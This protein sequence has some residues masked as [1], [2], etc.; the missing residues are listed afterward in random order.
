[1]LPEESPTAYELW[2]DKRVTQTK[3]PSLESITP[4]TPLRLAVA[5]ALAYP[6]GSM[7]MSG[8]RREARRGRLSI[9]RIAGK[10]YTTLSDIE[11]MRVRC[12][13]E[14]KVRDSG[15]APPDGMLPDAEFAKRSGSYSTATGI[16]PQDALRMKLLK[17]KSSSPNTSRKNMS[18]IAA[19]A[20]LRT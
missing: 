8:L 4:M 18:P 2:R 10:D 9:E 1:M 11:Q 16:S 14:A 15:S 7:T 6:D 12:R 5:A 3:M 20:I 19:S 17:R 13:V